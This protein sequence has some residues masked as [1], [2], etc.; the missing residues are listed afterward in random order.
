MAGKLFAPLADRAVI[1]VAGADAHGFLQ[2]LVTNDVDRVAP[3]RAI[4][5]ALLTPQGRYLFDFFIVEIDGTL[6]LDCEAARRDELLRRLAM[7]RLRAKVSLASA[8]GLA[9]IA[10]F[11]EGAVDALGLAENAGVARRFAGGVAYVDPRNAKA[12]VRVLAPPDAAR[13]ALEAAGFRDGQFS[14]YDTMRIAA[15]LPD[16]GRDMVAERALLLE[17]GFEALNGVDFEKGCYVGQEV[18]TR[19]KRR[20]LVKKLL[21]PVMIEGRAPEPGTKILRGD[22][23]AG[24][25][26]S[27]GDGAGLALLRLDMVDGGVALTAGEARIVPRPRS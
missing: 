12:G 5:A 6:H 9:T 10:A 15:G 4:Y 14:D 3:D 19:M 16:S 20:D 17:L 13:A 2:G 25:L 7:Y 21:M 18:T 8:D 11:G 22:V 26:R 1:A 24:E 27:S 23:E